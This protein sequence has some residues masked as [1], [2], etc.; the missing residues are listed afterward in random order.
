MLKLSNIENNHDGIITYEIFREVQAE[1]L[2]RSNTDVNALNLGKSFNVG[3]VSLT[4]IQGHN[5]E[6]NLQ[7]SIYNGE[8]EITGI[9]DY[10]Y[11]QCCKY[12]L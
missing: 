11:Y 1:K 9:D 10:T 7:Y 12:N 5:S 6:Y 8:V 2:N 4:T 3:I